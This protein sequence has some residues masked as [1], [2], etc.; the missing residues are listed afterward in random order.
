MT[1]FVVRA[2]I[3]QA[4]VPLQAIIERLPKL[5]VMFWSFKQTDF[6]SGRPFGVVISEFERLTRELSGGF[7]VANADFREFLRTDFQLVDGDV[8]AIGPAGLLLRIR[9]EDSTQWEL[10]TDDPKIVSAME[11]AGF[12]RGD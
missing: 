7:I 8:E 9:C 5:D 4:L 10:S 11:Q 1:T 3:N 2:Y 6:A 12:R